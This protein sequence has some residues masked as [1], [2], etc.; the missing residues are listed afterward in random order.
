[1]LERSD[2][3]IICVPTPLR[4]SKDLDI[5]LVVV[6]AEQVAARHRPG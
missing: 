1:V 4:K 6:A 3:V 5:S 2:V